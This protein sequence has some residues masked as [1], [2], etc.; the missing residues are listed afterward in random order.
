MNKL[1]QKIIPK[2]GIQGKLTF[3][4]VLLSTLPLLLL[5]IYTVNQQ[6]EFR[7]QENIQD[8]ET[9]V[10]GLKERTT[11]FLTKVESEL[12]LVLKSTESQKLLHNL[13][14]NLPVN[15]QLQQNAEK[16]Y[17]NIL[18]DND[19]YFRINLLNKKGKEIISVMN[20][21]IAPYA[22]E[23]NKL[24]KVTHIFYSSIAGEM[25]PGE[26]EL[27][28]SEIK[29]PSS[30]SFIPVI[31]FILPVY[32]SK[33][34]LTAIVTVNILAEK[35]FELLVPS[36][37]STLKKILIVNGEGYYVFHSQRKNNWD[38]LLSNRFDENVFRDYSKE[39]AEKILND[40]K[41]ATVFYQ[42]RIIQY[43][44]IFSGSKAATDRYFIIEDMPAETILP[45][46]EKLK[47]ISIAL[48]VI[49]G[50]ISLV[51]GYI[52]AGRFLKP[53]KQLIKGTQIIRSGNLDYKLEIKTHDEI[54]ELIN[55]FNQL[56][57]E[58]RYK[59]IL[60]KEIRKSEKLFSSL[61]E[62]ASDAILQIDS[63][64]NAIV[65]NDAATKIFGYSK[66]EIL[67]KNVLPL[68]IPEKY[69]GRAEK[70]LAE[71]L[72]SD[73]N[74]I[75]GDVIEAEA[76]TKDGYEFPAELSISSV[77]LDDSRYATGIIRDITNRKKMMRELITAKEK[78]E[79]ADKL[80][81]EF[82]NQMSHEIRTPLNILL[83]Y[84][85]YLYEELK[86]KGLLG[87][88]IDTFYLGIK[89]SG[90]RIIRTV[91]LILNMSEIQRGNFRNNPKHTDICTGI[92]DKLI[93]E[94]RPSAVGKGLKFN[95]K[96]NDLTCAAHV[97]PYSMEQIF[98][99]LIDNAIKF[100][101]KGSITIALE[102]NE[103]NKLVVAI[104]DTG[105]GISEEYIPNLYKMF[106]QEQQGFARKYDGNGLGLALVK[107]L[108]DMNNITIEVSSAKGIGTKFTLTFA[109]E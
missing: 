52:T 57:I 81:S 25:G 55:N 16:E 103:Q 105:I 59:Q 77:Y 74:P 107:N 66:N 21:S 64:G 89:E 10:K 92:L 34:K 51:V 23:K 71:F 7:Q 38:M 76:L 88:D 70:E 43:S 91:E 106:S 87:D 53:I 63:N 9:D 93:E 36:H 5:S 83:T 73:A 27:S 98:N 56:V 86:E 54:Q 97:D 109:N 69:R 72:K 29:N 90:R 2:F 96:Q 48:I 33:N 67:G 17:L 40:K 35:L 30:D 44:P 94:Y 75:S 47:T 42:D 102:R 108:C 14:Y 61:A 101:E 19:F 4:F 26:I 1:F 46:I 22:I 37:G 3:I 15:T 68:I 20:D 80:K 95:L 18:T 32:N 6:I 65:W 84:S 60:E 13:E 100:T 24:S 79:H 99:H 41:G 8:L 62:T 28:P 50:L 58:W 82:L 104:Q 45:P 31:D 39:I 49:V 12:W 85:E 11:L 78:A